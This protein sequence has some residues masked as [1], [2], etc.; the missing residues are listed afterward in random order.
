MGEMGEQ[1]IQA[2]IGFFL[3]WKRGHGCYGYHAQFLEILGY[4]VN[5][6]IHQISTK[7]KRNQSKGIG[8]RVWSFQLLGHTSSDINFWFCS[9][10][11]VVDFC[12]TLAWPFGRRQAIIWTSAEILLIGPL[13]TNSS[14]I[15][16]GIQTFSFKKNPFENV[17]CEMASI[18]L[19]LE[20]LIKIIHKHKW[21]RILHNIFWV[22]EHRYNQVW[23]RVYK[24][25]INYPI[26]LFSMG[27]LITPSCHL[28]IAM[29]S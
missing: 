17:V 6:D 7:F 12:Q 26:K 29:T 15:L 5:G 2:L 20:V 22:Y 3:D 23:L 25:T 27:F 4:M 14:E 18:C 21:Q 16:I 9:G 24:G 10:F 28:D 11:V 13:G 1:H 8:D 19:G